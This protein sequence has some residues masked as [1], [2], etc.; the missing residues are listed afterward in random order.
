VEKYREPKEEII[1]LEREMKLFYFLYSLSIGS[2]LYSAQ[3]AFDKYAY[4]LSILA[5][6]Q[7]DDIP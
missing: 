1:G 3:V 7:L 6:E 2:A 4:I 5:V